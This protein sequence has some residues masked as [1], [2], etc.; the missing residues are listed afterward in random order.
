MKKILPLFLIILACAPHLKS[1][2]GWSII[3]GPSRPCNP[4]GICIPKKKQI[5]ISTP[6]WAPKKCTSPLI[7]SHE[8]AHAWGL[9]G[10]SHIYCLLYEPDC[11][12]HKKDSLFWESIAKPFQLLYGFRFCPDCLNFLKKKG[13]L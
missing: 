10:C 11:A 13:A 8:L 2:P 3:E 7:T 5:V 12:G 6:T 9:H 4:F 1:P